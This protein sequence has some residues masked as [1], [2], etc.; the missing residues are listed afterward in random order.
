MF[1]HWGIIAAVKQLFIQTSATLVCWVEAVLC[2]HRVSDQFSLVVEAQNEPAAATA[3]LCSVVSPTHLC[4]FLLLSPRCTASPAAAGGV[5]G[6]A[7]PRRGPAAPTLHPEG[8]RH[9]PEQPLPSSHR[10]NLLFNTLQRVTTRPG[11]ILG[12]C[13]AAFKPWKVLEKWQER[14][15]ILENKEL[16]EK[17]VP[18]SFP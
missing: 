2:C 1:Q 12:L 13:H 16:F 8:H 14:P 17:V 18:F 7:A 15:K 9:L 11:K 10:Y 4:C 5:P 3:L 6:Q